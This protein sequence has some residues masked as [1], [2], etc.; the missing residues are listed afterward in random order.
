MYR[1]TFPRSLALGTLALA[2]S[3]AAVAQPRVF[4]NNTLRG[5][6]KFGEYPAVML[7]GRET[8]LSP[9]SRVRTTE[10]LIVSATSLA[11]AKWLVHYTLDMG[12]EQVRDVWLLTPEEAAIRPWPSTPEQAATW[13]FDS[14]TMTWSRP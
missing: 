14:T 13:T 1:C 8:T 10:N 9:G 7:N 6:L 3:A 5:L 2:F 12:G 11:G 4:P